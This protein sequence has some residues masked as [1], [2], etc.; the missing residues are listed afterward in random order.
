MTNESAIKLQVLYFIEFFTV[1]Y[2]LVASSTHTI[3]RTVF[4]SGKGDVDQM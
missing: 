1:Q 4:F 2:Y 3:P